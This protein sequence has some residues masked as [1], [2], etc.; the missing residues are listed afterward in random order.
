MAAPIGVKP[1]KTGGSHTSCKIIRI[2]VPLLRGESLKFRF[3]VSGQKFLPVPKFRAKN[4]KSGTFCREHQI[5]S[6]SQNF[7]KIKPKSVNYLQNNMY[8]S[9]F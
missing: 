4:A 1:I 7:L 9:K 3:T 8:S 6:K 2:G 5:F